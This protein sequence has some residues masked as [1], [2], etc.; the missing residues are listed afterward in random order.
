MVPDEP[1]NARV[2]QSTNFVKDVQL[3]GLS[4]PR[5]PSSGP[6][7]VV[8]SGIH[9]RAF[10]R[11]C[12]RIE[13]SRPDSLVESISVGFSLSGFLGR[14]CLCSLA[15]LSFG[16]IFFALLVLVQRDCAFTP[17]RL[18]FATWANAFA[19]PRAHE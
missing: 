5:R 16:H 14:F 10:Y 17:T 9:T 12:P 6:S 2:H 18:G 19:R 3:H 13:L 1:D 8:S 11:T 4:R 7:K 15:G